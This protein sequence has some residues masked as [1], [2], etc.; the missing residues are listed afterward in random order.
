LLAETYLARHQGS[1]DRHRGGR[2]SG[3]GS[4]RRV[5]TVR[6]VE[7]SSAEDLAG[8]AGAWD[9][10]ALA[11]PERLPM[12]SHA[13][14]ASVLEH[15]RPRAPWRCLFAYEG[16]RLVGVLPVVRV[17]RRLPG[18][19]FSGP[20]AAHL[21]TYSAYP[22]LDVACARPALSAL[23]TELAVDEPRFTWLRLGGVRSDAAIMS[24]EELDQAR[25]ATVPAAAWRRSGSL[26]P[27]HGSFDDYQ[28][29]LSANFRRNLRKARNRCERQH[30]LSVRFVTGSDA[31]SREHFDAFLALESSGWKGAAGTAIRCSPRL[32]EFY[33]ALCRRMSERGWLEWH[34]LEFDGTPVA[35]HLA[36]R[37]GRSLVL[38]K[39]AYDEAQA[40]LGPGNLLFSD[41]V[42]R[43][44]ATDGLSEINCLSDTSWHRN[45]CMSTVDYSDLVITPSRALPRLVGLVEVRG[46]ALARRAAS[47]ARRAALDRAAAV[48]IVRHRD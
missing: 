13:W 30:D 34:F 41:T 37:F 2:S 27:L 3:T 24:V 39:I 26:L 1:P 14:V 32:E 29:R 23:L 8:H 33:W 20:L 48:G 21:H 7:A 15:D 12:L 4:L 25:L 11:A 31:G 42:A 17:R 28:D 47:R 19:R 38:L 35:G 43:A 36:I 44:F 18:V 16:Q 10:L 9:E 5:L 22:L 45:W 40:R 6:V 46:A